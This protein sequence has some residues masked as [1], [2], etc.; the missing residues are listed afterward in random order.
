MIAL[1][2][3]KVPLIPHF[4]FNFLYLSFY[5]FGLL[6]DFISSGLSEFNHA[7]LSTE[8]SLL[9]KKDGNSMQVYNQRFLRVLFHC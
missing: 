4:F 3:V 8:G 2:I 5:G 1:N 7:L 6:L 9:F